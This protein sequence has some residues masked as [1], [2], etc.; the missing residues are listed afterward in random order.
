M[1]S[2]VNS[3]RF[4]F[5][6]ARSRRLFNKEFIILDLFTSTIVRKVNDFY[7]HFCTELR[8]G[9]SICFKWS[10]RYA[11]ILWKLAIKAFFQLPAAPL[12][13]FFARSCPLKRFCLPLQRIV[14]CFQLQVRKKTFLREEKYKISYNGRTGS[15]WIIMGS[16]LFHDKILY[17]IN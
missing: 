1:I 13:F 3:L 4:A 15:N 10:C 12:H 8:V 6:C 14:M 16:L 17:K 9:D 11:N 2:F 5:F 7:S